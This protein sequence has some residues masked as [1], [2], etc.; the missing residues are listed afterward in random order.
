[1]KN[2][3]L[4]KSLI[5]SKY[6]II[7]EKKNNAIYLSGLFNLLIFYATEF[8]KFMLDDFI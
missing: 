5:K 1:M 4:N 8:P 2:S 7:H 6:E 3:K